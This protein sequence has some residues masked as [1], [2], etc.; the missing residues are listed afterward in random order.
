MNGNAPR[1]KNIAVVLASGT[2]TR[3][4]AETPK[5]FLKVSGKTVLEHTLDVFE[6]H[7]RVD[8][9]IVV[10]ALD[11]VLLTEELVNRAGYRKV[12]RVL[13]GG[14]TRQRSS[15]CGIA[16]IEGDQH[17]V[18][19][20][21]AVRPLLDHATIDRCLDAL[22]RSDAV[23]TTI[24]ASDTVVRVSAEQTITEIP[25]R[26]VLHLGQT[27]QAFRA[28]LLRKAHRRA[29]TDADL[30][31][32]DDCGLIVRYGLAPVEVVRGDVNNIKITYPS[33][34]YLVDR[35]FQLRTRATPSPE[36]LA[37]D[38]REKVLVVFGASRGIGHSIASIAAQL[39]AY[40]HAVS[41]AT[42]VDVSDQHKVRKALQEAQERYGRVDYVINTAGVL[43]TG[44]LAGQDY[45]DIDEQIS[46]NLRGSLVVAREAFEV[47]R[48]TGGSI[49]LFT[50]SSYTRGRARYSV[51]SAT[52][53]AIVNLVQALAEEFLPFNVR[54][55][56]LN[57]ERTDTPMR[58]EN[59]GIEPSGE[60]LTA[61]QVARATLLACVGSSTG[62]V[63]DVRR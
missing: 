9:I 56:A 27:P 62:E 23:D 10:S 3:F 58:R 41:R 33:D 60:L 2:S 21:D 20:H 7:F 55:N 28:G 45:S 8:E 15:A 42:G 59:F 40:T 14:D 6:R 52:K 18:L 5:Q 19:V 54:I 4:G 13:A 26:S 12:T 57:P 38:L 44:L 47:M 39:G 34:I 31:V 37:G 30:K 50:S 51:Y 22:D 63:L 35:I 32:T 49:V 25:D 36:D 43:R 16:A 11:K 53:A 61:E 24:P 46:T 29:S 48:G 1:V 17:K